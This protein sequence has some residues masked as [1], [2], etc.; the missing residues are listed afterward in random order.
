MTDIDECKTYPGK[1]HVNATCSNTH[2][3]HVCPCKPGY[4]GDGHYCTGTVNNLES[5]QI[6]FDFNNSFF[7]VVVAF[8]T[9]GEPML[10]FCRE[11]QLPTVSALLW[12]IE[13]KG[14]KFHKYVKKQK[15]DDSMYSNKI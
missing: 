6:L 1:C 8:Y 13:I 3:L 15:E 7:F 11:R 14:V 5:S 9:H 4:T 12:V 2:G 10:N